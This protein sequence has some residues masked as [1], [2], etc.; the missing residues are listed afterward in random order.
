MDAIL[1]N[2]VVPRISREYLTRLTN[3]QTIT[4]V[5]LNVKDGDFEYG[6]D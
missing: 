5:A 6:F 3:G 1:T 2:T 4:K